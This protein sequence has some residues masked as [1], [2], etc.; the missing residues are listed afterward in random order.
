MTW[1]LAPLLGLVLQTAPADVW[2]PLRFL[3]GQWEGTASGK[4]GAGKTTR[5]YRF[6]LN[7]QFLVGDNRGVYAKETH[8]DRSIFSYDRAAKSFVLRQF[9]GEGFVNEYTLTGASPLEFLSRRIENIPEGWRARETYQVI[10]RDEFI[11]T[12]ALAAP[13]KDFEV[14]SETRLKRK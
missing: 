6:E 14:Y 3:V 9:H 13:G 1:V 12:F 5:E 4:P 10:G 2:A 7:G 8:Q 11:E